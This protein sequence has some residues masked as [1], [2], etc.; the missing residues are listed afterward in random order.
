MDGQGKV[1]EPLPSA[2]RKGLVGQVFSFGVYGEL[3]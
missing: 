2:V 1:Q 3:M